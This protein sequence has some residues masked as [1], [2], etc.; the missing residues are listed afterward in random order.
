MLCCIPIKVIH[1]CNHILIPSKS[2][3]TE[4]TH[5]HTYVMITMVLLRYKSNEVTLYSQ[6]WGLDVNDSAPITDGPFLVG[7]LNVLVNSQWKSRWCCVKESHL[8][9]YQDRNRTKSAQ[10][11]LSLVGCEVIPNP[12]PDHLYSFRIL[13]NGEEIAVLE[14]ICVL[15]DNGSLQLH[16]ALFTC[17]ISF[18]RALWGR[19]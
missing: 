18:T 15:N 17:M 8:H 4:N 9:I 6:D 11:P 14:V 7:Y 1:K 3:P 10:Q 13:N 19:W 5:T 2:K 16:I 12:S